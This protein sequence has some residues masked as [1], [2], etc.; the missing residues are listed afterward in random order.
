MS[1]PLLLERLKD[2]QSTKSIVLTVLPRQG[3]GT[4]TSWYTAPGERV[5]FGTS[6][7]RFVSPNSVDEITAPC[8]GTIVALHVAEGTVV[9]PHDVLVTIR[10]DSASTRIPNGKQDANSLQTE[11]RKQATS[12]SMQPSTAQEAEST[13]ASTTPPSTG[14][15]SSSN[16]SARRSTMLDL[17]ILKVP[18][19]PAAPRP[20]RHKARPKIVKFTCDVTNEQ[21]GQLRQRA[22]DMKALGGD[23]ALAELERVAFDLLLALSDRELV[24]Y[25]ERRRDLEERE[26]YGYG[27]RPG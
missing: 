7:A 20:R 17:E 21:V 8:G 2:T 4:L 23:Y 9:A 14:D 26:R 25:L 19:L 6:L 27:N 11:G 16:T 22:Q 12:G 3:E 24:R 1:Q 10:P 18:D 5:E 13:S 15:T